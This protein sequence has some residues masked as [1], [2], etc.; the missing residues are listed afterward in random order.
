MTGVD[1]LLLS[2]H[3]MTEAALKIQ[4]KWKTFKIKRNK[5][6]KVKNLNNLKLFS[7]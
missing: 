3:F 6:P 2:Y 4:S 1:L 7:K 5:K